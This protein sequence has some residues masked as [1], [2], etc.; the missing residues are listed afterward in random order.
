MIRLGFNDE[1]NLSFA[2]VLSNGKEDT[3]KINTL[4]GISPKKEKILA[5]AREL[6]SNKKASAKP[7]NSLLDSALSEM[8][9]A[10]K[11]PDKKGKNVGNI[12]I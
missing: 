9:Y 4:K 11:A 8:G 2:I 10:P 6:M 1:N 12:K 7:N 3:Y 5:R